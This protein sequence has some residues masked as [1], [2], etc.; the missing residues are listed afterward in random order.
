[1]LGLQC[2]FVHVVTT[3]GA[4]PWLF[5]GGFLVTRS[6]TLMMIAAVTHRYT[7][8]EPGAGDSAAAVGRH[9]LV[10]AVPVPL[11]DLPDHPQGGRQP[12]DAAGSS[13]SAMVL[14]AA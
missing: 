9:P 6:A 1:M 14:T 5:R 7:I 2:W 10:R 12:A 4:D 3:D 8:T 13:R 11:A